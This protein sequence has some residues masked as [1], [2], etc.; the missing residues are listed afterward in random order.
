[1]HPTEVLITW[2]LT[3]NQNLEHYLSHPLK[4]CDLVTHETVMKDD[5]AGACMSGWQ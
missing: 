2:N 5:G 3:Y 1:M 4:L